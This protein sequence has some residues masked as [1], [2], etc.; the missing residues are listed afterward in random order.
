MK[1]SKDSKVLLRS[2][3]LLPEVMDEKFSGKKAILDL[4][5]MGMGSQ[6]IEFSDEDSADMVAMKIFK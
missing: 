1:K 5:D 3:I 4:E 2:N 6:E